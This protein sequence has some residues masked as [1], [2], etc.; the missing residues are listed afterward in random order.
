MNAE[1]VEAGLVYRMAPPQI[2]GQHAE[3][4]GRRMSLVIRPGFYTRCQ[5]EAFIGLGHLSTRKFSAVNRSD[6]HETLTKVSPNGE[7]SLW[8]DKDYIRN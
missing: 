7:S 8:T 1:T 3:L 5:V 4:A 2:S 6:A